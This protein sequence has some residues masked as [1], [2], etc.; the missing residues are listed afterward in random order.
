MPN[1]LRNFGHPPGFLFSEPGPLPPPPRQRGGTTPHGSSTKRCASRG[2]S[3]VTGGD[4]PPPAQRVGCVLFRKRGGL[5]P[6]P[7]KKDRP[8]PPSVR[9]VVPDPSP[10]VDQ[11]WG[12]VGVAC[13]AGVYPSGSKK[14]VH[15]GLLVHDPCVIEPN[16]LRDCTKNGGSRL[17]KEELRTKRQ[18][19]QCTVSSGRS[20]TCPD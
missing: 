7:Q 6:K 2:A 20:H 8:H 18:L 12:G 9:C 17:K 16:T 14:G 19:D 4:L 13:E 15:T 11:K 10:L 5:P 1:P 3:G